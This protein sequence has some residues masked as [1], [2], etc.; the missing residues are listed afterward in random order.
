MDTDALKK[1]YATNPAT[2]SICD[3]LAS[4]ERNQSETKLHRIQYHLEQ[5][6]EEFRKADV[7][8]AFR[9]LEEAGCGKYVEGRHGWKSRFVWSVNSRHLAAVAV[10]ADAAEAEE[11]EAEQVDGEAVSELIEHTYW[12]RPDLSVTFE[13]PTDLSQ[14][15]AQRVSQF[16]D[17][18]SFEE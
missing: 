10:G 9:A 8:G 18:L 15:E 4:R 3:H 17:S 11:Y 6:G 12:L 7:I 2:K 13:L 1:A 16:I 14:R 5:E